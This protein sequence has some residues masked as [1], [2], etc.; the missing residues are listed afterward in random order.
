M[1]S[2]CWSPNDDTFGPQVSG[3]RAEFDFTVHFEELFLVIAPAALTVL[4]ILVRW[5]HLRTQP[6]CARGG[7]LLALKL[8]TW[9]I[10]CCLKAALV[11]LWVLYAPRTSTSISAAALSLV[12][13]LLA[14]ALLPLE[15]RYSKKPSTVL[16][17]YLLLTSLLDI[18]VIQS[19]IANRHRLLY[20][21]IKDLKWAIL[22]GAVPRAGVIGF[23][24]AQPFM[25]NRMIRWLDALP[26]ENS[27]NEGY[28]LIAAFS[29]VF[30]CLALCNARYQHLTYRLV[31]MIRTR[32][33][34]MIYAKTLTMNLQHTESRAPL[35]LMS[36]DIERIS[37][38][39]GYLHD[40]WGSI[41]EVAIAVWLLWR[42]LG[43]PVVATILI[44][45]LCIVLAMIVGKESGRRQQAWIEAVQRR[46]A[47]T[48]KVLPSMKTIKMTGLV[49]SV[50]STLE[51]YRLDEVL[52]SKRWR[53]IQVSMVAIGFL[54]SALAPVISLT[55]Y[56]LT[57]PNPGSALTLPTAMTVLSIFALVGAPLHLLSESASGLFTAIACV[58]RIRQ[59]L[60][61]PDRP[62]RQHAHRSRE[63]ATH[64]N[65]ETDHKS[66]KIVIPGSDASEPAIRLK[67]VAFGWSRE[68]GP[69]LS[70]L[71][72]T[73]D[74]S[75]LAVV[76]GPVGCGKSTLFHGLLSEIHQLR[77]EM[78][79]SSS[80]IAYCSQV[81][82]ITNATLRENIIG[83]TPYDASRYQEVIAC[84]SLTRDIPAL[85]YGDET[86]LGSG[87]S[88]ISG[89][90]KQRVSLAR[91]VYSD[92]ELLLL[93]DVLSGLDSATEER[94]LR[95]LLGPGGLLH[96]QHRTVILASSSRACITFADRVVWLDK[97]GR[98]S[99][100]ETVTEI[101]PSSDSSEAGGT[102]S[103]DAGARYGPD[104]LTNTPSP[105]AEL[106]GTLK[107][108][109]G[110]WHVLQYYVHNMGPLGMLAFTLLMTVFVFLYCFPPVWVQMW[111][112]AGDRVEMYVG[113]YYMVA[114]LQLFFIVVTAAYLLL[115]LL[116]QASIKFH[117][118]LLS[119]TTN[120]P[121]TFLTGVDVG[122]TTNR[123]SQ[124]LQIIDTE[125]PISLLN[126]L[127]AFGSCIM[128][129]V[130]ICVS[131]RYVAAILPFFITILYFLQRFYLHSSQQI[132]LLDIAAKAPLFSHFS[133]TLDGLLHLRALAWQVP[134]EKRLQGLL[135]ASQRPFYILYCV[136][137]WLNLVLDL[138]IAGL[139][140]L[141]VGVAVALRGS[142]STGLVGLALVNI[143]SLN[144]NMRLLVI[145][146]TTLETSIAA[147]AR[148][149]AYEHLTPSEVRPDQDQQPPAG[150]PLKG[151][152]E[153]LE[154]SA[155]YSKS[156]PLVLK[157][158][159]LSIPAGSKIGICGRSGSGKSSLFSVLLRMLDLHNGSV[160]IDGVDISKVPGKQVRKQL[161]AIAQ[162]PFFIPNTS[163]RACI[164][165]YGSLGDEEIVTILKEIQLWE[166]IGGDTGAL[167]T[168]ADHSLFSHGQ[169]QLLSLGR[170]LG[171]RTSTGNILLL[172]EATSQLD[173][174]TEKTVQQVI[175]RCFSDHT[176]IAIAHRLETIVGYD[177]VAVLD[178]GNV[179]EIGAPK[180]LLQQ[181]SSVFKDLW[182]KQQSGK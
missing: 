125:L 31:V 129:L 74:K 85:T 178:E 61:S 66:E 176:V 122:V 160:L 39:L 6:A 157:H 151:S 62:E 80:K 49:G 174:D 158:A 48:A 117:R 4:S 16:L 42:E 91:A 19:H 3:C 52:A 29:L 58:E 64:A 73:I 10:L 119:V 130:I 127:M 94:L 77:G 159:S 14:A 70:R 22:A 59:F 89:G 149:R 121:L 72:L 107:Q 179:V 18:A 83:C 155:F 78:F 75:T 140:V 153:I 123:F 81:P 63:K 30:T 69:T 163:V 101:Q 15:H 68:G 104:S 9:T 27:Q 93:D 97:T 166:Q 106:E 150:W 136:Q 67:D 1:P 84:C 128:L 23:K 113:I 182:E 165:P 7:K 154:A 82:W 20:V 144:G 90:Q 100:H 46:I 143:I 112:R 40:V 51:K 71:D 35:T 17:I 41:V 124:D 102:L 114:V 132:R 152:V 171:R 126:T 108:R 115:S 133:E 28:G 47:V 36:T 170:A 135:S 76:V 146:W 21:L 180:D 141:L 65:E 44:A 105:L 142:L 138:T 156:G 11:A 43:K 12:S 109:K 134:Y 54:H 79:V 95:D 175:C 92:A 56:A 50:T 161:N 86:K 164:D 103:K 60:V 33:V 111:A 162:E 169:L 24:Y 99:T 8:T 34:A 32:L 177:L 118:T 45:S 139:A 98:I 87:G 88:A 55:S 116:P 26:S 57:S 168:I 148:I 13:S 167:D 2:G 173:Q 38:G 137:R 120:A 25:T 5:H 145:Q 53:G 181:P 96:R 147:V 37:A 172:D 110:D 131:G